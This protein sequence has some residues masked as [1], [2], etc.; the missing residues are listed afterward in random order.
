MKEPD[1]KAL[2]VPLITP[3]ATDTEDYN[4]PCSTNSRIVIISLQLVFGVTWGIAWIVLYITGHYPQI[5]KDPDNQEQ[6]DIAFEKTSILFGFGTFVSCVVIVGVILYNVYMVMFGMVY[7]IIQS[8]LAIIFLS[9]ILMP[10]LNYYIA[11]CVVY[12]M[13]FLHPHYLFVHECSSGMQSSSQYDLR[14]E[15]RD[16]FISSTEGFC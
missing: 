12:L 5:L 14:E 11:A 9:P 10:H 1:G 13:I 16:L 6:S 4:S 15:D 3:V 8:V 2:K 7:A